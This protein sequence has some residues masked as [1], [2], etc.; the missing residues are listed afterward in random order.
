MRYLEKT[1]FYRTGISVTESLTK[2]R[3]SILKQAQNTF[4]FRNVWTNQG[5]IFRNVKE[6]KIQIKNLDDTNRMKS[7]S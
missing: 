4:G 1:N 6:K 2:R 3:L 5:K 7:D